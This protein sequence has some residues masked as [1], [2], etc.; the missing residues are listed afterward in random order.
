MNFRKSNIA[1][2]NETDCILCSL[3]RSDEDVYKRVCRPQISKGWE[4]LD[5]TLAL[6]PTFKC[7]TVIRITSA[8]GLN[9]REVEGSAKLIEKASLPT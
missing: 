6:L 8:R 3:D 2:R 5:E 9:I 7:P 4:K 1:S